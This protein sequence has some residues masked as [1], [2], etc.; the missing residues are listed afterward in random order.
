[1][2]DY[3]VLEDKPTY[4][5]FFNALEQLPTAVSPITISL[6]AWIWRYTNNEYGN[7]KRGKG[8]AAETRLAKGM[9]VSTKTVQRAFHDAWTWG[10][11]SRE[12][13][14]KGV[15]DRRI[16]SSAPLS[17]RHMEY[18]G[19]RYWLEFPTILA[20]GNDTDHTPRT[21]AEV[22]TVRRER[23]MQVASII[24]N[25]ATPP[26]DRES[27]PPVVT[28]STPPLDRESLRVVRESTDV[29][30]DVSSL[31]PEAPP[32]N[33]RVDVPSDE[34]PR[35]AVA[36]VE[37]RADSGTKILGGA[38]TAIHP[39]NQ[40]TPGRMVGRAT[41]PRSRPGSESRS[42]GVLP[43]LPPTQAAPSLKVKGCTGG[44]KTKPFNYRNVRFDDLQTVWQAADHEGPLALPR[45]GWK[46]TEN[47]AGLQEALRQ[48]SVL[49]RKDL[50]LPA[51]KRFV[52][53]RCDTSEAPIFA[54]LTIFRMEFQIW[55]DEIKRQ[56]AAQRTRQLLAYDAADEVL[57]TEAVVTVR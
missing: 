19:A 16:V 36:G 28:E 5:D 56:Q 55:V 38:E 3:T 1:M 14:F 45:I 31:T 12:H 4:P 22:S 48:A 2:N 17:Q 50:V 29:S 10:F 6:L 15:D 54:P 46:G 32:E 43:P 11:V 30:I 41:M 20:W 8:W 39:T 51:F 9:H 44:P 53:D 27:T 25:L 23:V 49:D 18:L 40:P 26:L 21:K 57:A 24:N 13:E 34:T 42:R 7:P 52:E 47:S 35:G 37:E 33:V